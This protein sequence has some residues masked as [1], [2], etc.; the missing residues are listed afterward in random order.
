MTP[1]KIA[2]RRDEKIF[3]GYFGNVTFA[4]GVIHWHG[5]APDSWFVHIS[6]ETNAHQN[7]KTDWLDPV[8]D[9]EYK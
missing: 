8:T 6:V 7:G 9:K 2:R 5:A 4:P 3:N 1:E